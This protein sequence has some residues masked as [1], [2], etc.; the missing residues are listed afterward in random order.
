MDGV[1]VWKNRGEEGVEELG[2]VRKIED[3]MAFEV[4]GARVRAVCT[5][6]HTEDHVVFV[7]E[8]E[9]A[10]FTG[11]NVLGHG[12]SVFEDLGGY[13]GSLERMRGLFEGEKAR[14]GSGRAYPGHGP[15]V[16]DGLGKVVEYIRHRGQRE[17]QVLQRLKGVVVD[18]ASAQA[19]GGERPG[20]D[21][22]WSVMELVRSI[23]RDVPESLHPAAAGGVVQILQKLLR[24]GKVV[25]DGEDGDRWR[26]AGRSAL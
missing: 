16:E 15:V 18:E 24:E 20:A 1:G 5:P 22:G 6:G 10:V 14:G 17:E 13:V 9:G 7:W 3:G 21:G 25:E 8:G 23:Y 4:E 26:L 11:D 2:V 12:T 19:E